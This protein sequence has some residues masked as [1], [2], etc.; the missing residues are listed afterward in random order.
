MRVIIIATKF[1]PKYIP[2]KSEER[3]I[4]VKDNENFCLIEKVKG[5]FLTFSNVKPRRVSSNISGYENKSMR[6]R[7]MN[8]KNKVTTIVEMTKSR[9]VKFVGVL[10][11]VNTIIT[12][13]IKRRFSKMCRDETYGAFIK[14]SHLFVTSS[15]PISPAKIFLTRKN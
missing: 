12:S 7:L 1:S 5:N 11:I 4:S 9:R 2:T 10:I 15:F 6:S 13:S 14:K 3:K 8:E